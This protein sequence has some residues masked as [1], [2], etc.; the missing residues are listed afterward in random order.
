MSIKPEYAESILNGSKRYEFRKKVFTRSDVTHVVL[1]ASSPVKKVVG[2]FE[3][4]YIIKDDLNS[5]WQRTKDN[6]GID[7]NCF[8]NYFMNHSEGHA[9]AIN[10]VIKYLEPYDLKAVFNVDPPQSYLYLK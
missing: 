1:Y 2:E 3:I 10:K 9:I 7:R 8:D 4:A 6:A 5:L